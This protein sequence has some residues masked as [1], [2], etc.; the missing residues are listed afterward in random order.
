MI[1]RGFYVTEENLDMVKTVW[2][3]F[4]LTGNKNYDYV[5]V[6]HEEEFVTF[7]VAPVFNKPEATTNVYVLRNGSRKDMRLYDVMSANG[8]RMTFLTDTRLPL[9]RTAISAPRFGAKEV[10]GRGF[11]DVIDQIFGGITNED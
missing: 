10:T 4:A 1:T 3:D 11:G 9:Y 6:T 5:T 2:K 8:E 7:K